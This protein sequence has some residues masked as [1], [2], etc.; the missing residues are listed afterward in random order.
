MKV[1]CNGA[2]READGKR[3]DLRLLR[4]LSAV[5]TGRYRLGRGGFD[6][7]AASPLD[8]DGLVDCTGFV[9]WCLMM[10]RDQVNANKPWSKYLPWIESSLIVRDATGRQVVFVRIDEPVPG[11]VATVGDR[12]QRQGHAAVV[13][14]AD[15]KG[16][17]WIVDASPAVPAIRHRPG[18]SFLK[19]PGIVFCL[20]R[21]DLLLTR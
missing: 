10:R 21:E 13:S 11:C 2:E 7:R 8:K 4:A 20:L 6:P 18:G 1:K 19:R 17:R 16:E 5:G 14:H 3:L 12:G 15:A 9:A